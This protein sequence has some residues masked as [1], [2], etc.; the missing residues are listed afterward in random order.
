MK[1]L[2]C[3]FAIWT[4]L[5]FTPAT[6]VMAQ[7]SSLP[8]P[9]GTPW[10]HVQV[11]EE[12]VDAEKISVNLPLSLIQ[13]AIEVAP[14]DALSEAQIRLEQHGLS[15]GD[16]RRLWNELRDAG[17]EEFVTVEN[18]EERVRVF[19][20]GD[21]IVTSRFIDDAAKAHAN[22]AKMS[23]ALQTNTSVGGWLIDQMASDLAAPISDPSPVPSPD[24]RQARLEQEPKK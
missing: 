18:S 3:C 15:V 17:Q 13:V 14:E 24:D 9:A 5:L 21:D 11:V 16:L 10:I 4:T 8:G 2:A 22:R 1:P 7:E 6:S 20:R 19:R 23:G 12:G